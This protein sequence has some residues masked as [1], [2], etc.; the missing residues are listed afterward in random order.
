MRSF[1]PQKPPQSQGMKGGE[2]NE[3]GIPA[4]TIEPAV[5]TTEKCQT[6]IAPHFLYYNMQNAYAQKG[7]EILSILLNLNSF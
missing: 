2:E 6:F 4:L 5:R 1:G 3:A 7:N